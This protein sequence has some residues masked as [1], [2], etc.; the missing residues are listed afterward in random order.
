M[1]PSNINKLNPTIP[2]SKKICRIL[3]CG[4]KGNNGK[5]FPSYSAKLFSFILVSF[6][7]KNPDP[8]TGC[9]IALS[10]TKFQMNN[11]CFAEI[12][13][14]DA[15][16]DSDL[17]SIAMDNIIINIA[18]NI[19]MADSVFGFLKKLKYLVIR[20]TNP[21]AENPTDPARL[22]E[23]IKVIVIKK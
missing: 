21:A 8:T 6:D 18:E 23:N 9:S 4:C 19:N 11:L 2:V 17:G 5:R 10:A 16:S 14:E 15:L 7:A 12:G 22:S 20:N 3:L 1:H 13:K